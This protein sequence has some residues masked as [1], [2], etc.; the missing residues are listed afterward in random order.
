VI[1]W[2]ACFHLLGLVELHHH[3]HL[4]AWFLFWIALLVM[5]ETW[6]KLKYTAVTKWRI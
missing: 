2:R 6:K 1:A 5:D 3:C 4:V